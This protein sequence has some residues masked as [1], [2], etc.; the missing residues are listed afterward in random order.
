MTPMMADPAHPF[1]AFFLIVLGAAP[2]TFAAAAA[3]TVLLD[4]EGVGEN[5]RVGN[6]YNGGG[7]GPGKNYGVVFGSNAL[8][9]VDSD[10]GGAGPIS[11]EPSNS[12]VL[13]LRGDQ[14]QAY[15]TVPGGFT[16]MSFQYASTIDASVTLYGGPD[17]T[18]TVLGTY[19]LPATGVCPPSECGD[20]NGDLGIWRNFTVPFGSGA[21]AAVVAVS[22][23]FPTILG[24]RYLFLDDVLIELVPTNSPTNAPTE[25]PSNAPTAAPTNVPTSAPTIVPTSSPSD[26]P[27]NRPTK[28]P[29]RSPTKAPPKSPASTTDDCPRRK[30]RMGPNNSARPCMMMMTATTKK[31]K[32]V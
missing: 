9:V 26:A 5:Q 30:T 2:S 23:G 19:E 7:G 13:W 32:A 11:R 4:F 25:P 10:A 8:G 16:G 12:T 27:T 28:A 14:A 15:A 29:T 31:P 18:G 1:L 24:F 20:P 22:A 6:Y 21:A 3:T 17:R